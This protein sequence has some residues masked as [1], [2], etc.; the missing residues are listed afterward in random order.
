[1]KLP[2]DYPRVLPIE[3]EPL[4]PLDPLESVGRQLRLV[5][6]LTRRHATKPIA[7]RLRHVRADLS[8]R[9]TSLSQPDQQI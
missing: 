6:E 5:D 9:L 2:D 4:R 8:R 1:M 3:R 7:A